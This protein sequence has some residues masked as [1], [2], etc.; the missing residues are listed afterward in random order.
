MSRLAILGGE[1][2]VKGALASFNTIGVRERALVDEVLE[3]GPLSGFYGSWSKEFWGGPMVRRLEETWKRTF[4][5]RHAVSVNSNT[6]GL[7]AAMGAIGVGPGDEVIV[8]PYTMSATVVAPLFYGGNPTLVEKAIGPRTKAIL[9]V[10]LFGQ[11]ARLA[12]LRAL[13]DRYGIRLVEDNAQ[14]PLATE[15]G[16][17]AGTIGHIGVFSLNVHKH[18]Q[19]GEGG[20]CTTDDDELALR[21]QA[22]RNHGENVAE[23]IGLADISNLV[24]FNFRLSELSAAVAIAQIERGQAIVEE[25]V[26][27]AESLTTAVRGL[28]GIAAPAVREGCRHVYYLWCPRIDATAA[29]V[30]RAILLKALVAEGVPLGAGYVPPLYRLPLF[31]RGIAIGS[32]G[33]PFSITGRTYPDGLC[34][35]T[36]RLYEREL[37]TYEVCAYAPTEQQLAQMGAA[38]AKVWEH[39]GELAHIEKAA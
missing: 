36:E 39:R 7:I 27:I 13:A 26:K 18:V 32:G 29:G 3:K 28:P 10:N 11:P 35:V 4:L 25:R 16:R 33:W 6:S 37:V 30:S 34:P 17:F 38:F 5:C 15:H 1:P 24:G 19:S 14:A 20:I 2:E 22:I 21:L 31:R 8:P 12:Q 23:E 9:A